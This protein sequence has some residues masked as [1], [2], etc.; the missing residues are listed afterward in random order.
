MRTNSLFHQRKRSHV[1]NYDYT[2]LPTQSENTY[3]QE[4]L[5]LNSKIN[6]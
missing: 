4:A 2:P 3:N 5:K 6:H 1:E